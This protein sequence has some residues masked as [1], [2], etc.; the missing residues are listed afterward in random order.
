MAQFGS[1][2]F[3]IRLLLLP[4]VR[5]RPGFSQFGRSQFLQFQLSSEAFCNALSQVQALP[6]APSRILWR[7]SDVL[8]DC[9]S[10]RQA[11]QKKLGPK[12]VYTKN[13]FVSRLGYQSTS[14]R[15]SLEGEA[16]LQPQTVL[17][18]RREEHVRRAQPQQ[19]QAHAGTAGRSGAEPLHAESAHRRVPLNVGRPRPEPQYQRVGEPAQTCGKRS[20]ETQ[21]E[22][23]P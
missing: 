20:Q 10:E 16:R 6:S 8:V 9:Q 3:L 12:T 22:R 11:P 15:N 17:H 23:K 14:S 21:Q 19:Q 7:R 18:H 1:G 13:L 4:R 2:R 5:L